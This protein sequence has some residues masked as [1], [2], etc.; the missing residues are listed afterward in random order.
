MPLLKFQI[1]ITTHYSM[2]TEIVFKFYD[3]LFTFSTTG[4]R[5]SCHSS[6]P[7]YQSD[8]CTNEVLYLASHYS[9]IIIV[10][11][12]TSCKEVV[13]H[14]TIRQKQQQRNDRFSNIY[15]VAVVTKLLYGFLPL[16]KELLKHVYMI[17]LKALLEYAKNVAK[18]VNLEY[19]AGSWKQ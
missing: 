6:L 19:H 1:S 14:V 4:T 16:L 12:F 13:D 11:W 17:G 2:G 10:I 7:K 18:Y 9:K 8:A 5:R 3:G 15:I